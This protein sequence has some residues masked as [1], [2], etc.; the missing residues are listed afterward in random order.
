MKIA[1]EGDSF[2]SEDLFLRDRL[3]WLRQWNRFASDFTT[4]QT[5]GKNL[6]LWSSLGNSFGLIRTYPNR[7][8]QL[9]TC[10]NFRRNTGHE[11]PFSRVEDHF[12]Q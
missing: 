3:V 9:R 7:F 5:L 11:K 2:L 6:Q 10:P 1:V 4:G 8:G 12:Y